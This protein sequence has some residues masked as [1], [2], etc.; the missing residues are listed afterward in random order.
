MQQ[1][2]CKQTMRV[3]RFLNGCARA[4]VTDFADGDTARLLLSAEGSD[5]R[6]G[7]ILC[8]PEIVE[9]LIADAL[10]VRD[11]R[12]CTITKLGRNRLKRQVIQDGAGA[13][14]AFQSQH[15]DLT[16]RT[17]R[18]NGDLQSVRV[19]CNE[20]PLMRLK[21]RKCADGSP[22]ISDAAFYAG[23]QLRLDFTKGRLMQKV[24]VNWD[25][26]M[27]V[28]SRSSGAGGKAD[29][30]NV[31]LDARDRMNKAL[32]HVGPDLANVLTDVCCYLKGLETV[33]RERRWPPRSAKL[34]LRV[35]L[36]LLAQFYGFDAKSGGVG[37]I[38]S[39]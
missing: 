15:R 23:E 26:A 16:D 25:G 24:T 30:S 18:I 27:G 29:L 14:V 10:L 11:A 22:W 37:K 21:S 6:A 20:S 34:L 39:C 17:I 36:G 1:K 5:G 32:A 13:D 2:A 12:S 28:A 19:N 38:R 31:A 4:K 35:G 7:K 33:E 9:A 8:M 3:L